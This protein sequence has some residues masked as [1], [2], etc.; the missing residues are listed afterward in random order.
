MTTELV[1]ASK[2]DRLLGLTKQLDGWAVADIARVISVSI[3]Y[4][5]LICQMHR[6]YASPPATTLSSKIFAINRV[7]RIVHGP[8]YSMV[9]SA[10]EKL[11]QQR[12]KV[13][14][15]FSHSYRRGLLDTEVPE[16]ASGIPLCRSVGSKDREHHVRGTN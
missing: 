13:F 14:L 7:L 6:L 8:N 4:K 2:V 15:N 9:F 1:T 3:I 12:S 10:C 11:M 5:N 16:R